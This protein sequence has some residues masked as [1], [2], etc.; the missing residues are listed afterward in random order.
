[1]DFCTEFLLEIPSIFMAIE[2]IE[3]V[4]VEINYKEILVCPL[5]LKNS[6]GGFWYASA[7]EP[8]FNLSCC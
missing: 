5:S 3:M 7:F 8:E 1:M 4:G 2:F 6:D